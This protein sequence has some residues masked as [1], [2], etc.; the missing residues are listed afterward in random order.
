MRPQNI[1]IFILLLLLIGVFVSPVSASG[2]DSEDSAVAQEENDYILEIEEEFGLVED[3]DVLRRVEAI[4]GRLLDVVTEEEIGDR[5]V[6]YRI[7][8]EDIVNAFALPDGHIYLFMGLLDACE[9]DDML[10]GV[11]AHELTHVLHGHHARLNERQLR[12][13][14]IGMAAMVATGEGEALLLGEMLAASMVETYGRS[15]END[16]DRTGTTWTVQ[17]G[18]D[19]VGYMELMEILEQDAIHRPEP[20]GNYFTVHPHPDERMGNIRLV[21]AEMG[22]EIPDYIYRVHLSLRF[23]L[24]LDQSESDALQEWEDTIAGRAEGPDEEEPGESEIQEDEIPP[25]LLSEYR[26]RRD[27]FENINQPAS[28]AYGVIAVGDDSDSG[29]FYLWEE[30]EEALRTRAEDIIS[31][32]GD[33]FMS[34]LRS[35]DVQGRSVDGTPVLIADRRIIAY[36]TGNDA[37]LLGVIPE[38]AN[39]FRKERLRDILYRYYVNRRI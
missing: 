38:E 20:G 3:A 25:S 23:Y 19:P 36:T 11:M 21:L 27:I 7:L 17:A 37:E 35:Y 22:V 14:L 6:I 33:K 5:E 32:L 30:S 1:V 16:A 12:G 2:E 34:G 28:G 26:L 9:T 13:M 18:Y 39:G 24:P 10:A 15:A 31:R 8:D 4:E 29:V